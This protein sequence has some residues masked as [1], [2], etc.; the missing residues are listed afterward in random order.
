MDLFSILLESEAP[1]GKGLKVGLGNEIWDPNYLK[2][3]KTVVIKIL[4]HQDPIPLYK[5]LKQFTQTKLRFQ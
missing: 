1:S 2:G 3:E 5:K 4:Q